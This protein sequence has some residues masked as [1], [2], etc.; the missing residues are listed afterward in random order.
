MKERTKN[1]IIVA[2]AGV[3][4]FGFALWGVLMPDAKV[5]TSERRPLEQLPE[6]S[7]ES[8]TSGKFTGDFEEYAA[9]QFPLRD[10]FR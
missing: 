7:M 1:I 3:I 5:S 2:L 9:D 10:A 8:I 4:I 6:L